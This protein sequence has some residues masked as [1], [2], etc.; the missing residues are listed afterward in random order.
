M[1]SEII[2]IAGLLACLALD[3]SYSLFSI[4]HLVAQA[5][6][7]YPGSEKMDPPI[8]WRKMKIILEGGAIA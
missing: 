8:I 7:A 4:Q 1:N 3:C 2:S 6:S 5:Y